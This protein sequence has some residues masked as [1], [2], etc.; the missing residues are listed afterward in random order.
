MLNQL[1]IENFR[2]ITSMSLPLS[3]GVTAFIGE[4]GAGKTSIL[5]AV[6]L[7]GTGKPFST[8]R[9]DNVISRNAD[10]V[11]VVGHMA[12]PSK[13]VLG[14]RRNRGGSGEARVGGSAVKAL[15]EL[16]KAMPLVVI[17][18]DTLNIVRDGPEGRRRF[19]DSFVFHVEQSFAQTSRR[20]LHAL[21]QR[22][23][24]L[25][26]RRGVDD[27]VW[28]RDLAVAGELLAAYRDRAI[29]ALSHAV[30]GVLAD[31]HV[32]L[33]EWQ[34]IQR[35]GWGADRSLADALAMSVASDRQRGFTQVGPH[36]GDV[37]FFVEGSPA[38]EVL[39]RGQ[40]KVLM[41]A[42]KLAQA[43][44]MRQETGVA[45]LLLVDDVAAE[46]DTNNAAGLFRN[47]VSDGFQVLAT[48]VDASGP[49]AWTKNG[50]S[51]VF[52]VEH[53]A[54]TEAN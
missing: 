30:S 23:A 47:M 6:H 28:V 45:P 26:E 7:L 20:Y 10:A 16:A 35:C 44:V 9:I 42:T 24:L 5:D 13:V 46:L 29:S 52:H 33:P 22:N 43:R 31:M 15:S 14:V 1:S 51:N 27:A 36:R 3:K 34:L 32:S 49:T 48:M 4:N 40:M 12:G 41:A 53:G 19:I 2:N 38:H 17:N 37:V 25:R 54:I 18:A 8:H 39:S 11:Q 50:L 21:K